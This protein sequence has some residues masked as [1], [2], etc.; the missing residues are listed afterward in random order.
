MDKVFLIHTDAS[1]IA[2]GAT[3]SQEDQ[4]E[5]LKLVACGSRKLNDAER[6]YPPHEQ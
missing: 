4:Y 3:L 6:N 2:V 1:D 5:Q